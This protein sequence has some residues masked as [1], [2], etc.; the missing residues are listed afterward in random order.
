MVCASVWKRARVMVEVQ[1]RYG[2]EIKAAVLLLVF[3]LA[4]EFVLE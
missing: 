1:A 4:L 3:R 2:A